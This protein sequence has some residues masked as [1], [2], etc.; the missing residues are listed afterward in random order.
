MLWFLRTDRITLLGRQMSLLTRLCV[1]YRTTTM[2]LVA[3]RVDSR[4]GSTINQLL[5]IL[6]NLHLMD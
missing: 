3:R 2:G 5:G 4:S 6:R 1:F